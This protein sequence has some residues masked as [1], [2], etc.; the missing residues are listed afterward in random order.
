MYV[1]VFRKIE[2]ILNFEW[3]IALQSHIGPEFD[4]SFTITCLEDE[5]CIED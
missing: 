3:K 1:S 4:G 5:N 2:K